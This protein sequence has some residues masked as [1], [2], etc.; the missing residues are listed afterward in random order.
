M[1][2]AKKISGLLQLLNPENTVS[3]NRPLAHAIGLYETLVFSALISKYTYYETRNRVNNGWFFS[4]V[5]DL[6]ESTT[7]GE[8][9]Q[10]TAI[11]HLEDLQLIEYK[12]MG[13]PAKRYFRIIADVEKLDQLIC[14]GT[15]ISKKL[16]GSVKLSSADRA[17]QD[18]PFGGTSSDVW[19]E[20]DPPF[21]QNMFRCSGG[22]CP[23]LPAD[24]SKENKPKKTN[25]N[26]NQS[27]HSSES[28]PKPAEQAQPDGMDRMDAYKTLIHENIEYDSFAERYQDIDPKQRPSGSLQELNEIVDLM[29]ECIC[30]DAP[31]IRVA[32][33]N[34][35]QRAVKSQF[36]KINSEHIEYVLDCMEH[37]NTPVRNIKAYLITVLYN[38]PSTFEHYIAASVRYAISGDKQSQE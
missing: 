26:I 13:M 2:K 7:I 1:N 16:S 25:P 23:P 11:K 10:K 30:S 19:A 32:N 18:P 4:T 29:T 22:T 8:K 21:G 17:E 14:T 3:L 5:A 35:P 28:V 37:N 6:Q 24:K 36:L 20:Q 27:Y 38:A 34:M 15:E 33:Q 12:L 9:A 31:T